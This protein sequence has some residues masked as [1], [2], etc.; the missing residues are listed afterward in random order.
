MGCGE[1]GR[2]RRGVDGGRLPEA[3]SLT[4]GSSGGASE[5]EA[6]E[7]LLRL[8]ILERDR[9]WLLERR[10]LAGIAIWCEDQPVT[11]TKE[12][13]LSVLVRTTPGTGG[14]CKG[15]AGATGKG[16][17]GG[18]MLSDS[19]VACNGRTGLASGGRVNA[20][21]LSVVKQTG[22]SQGWEVAWCA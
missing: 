12:S 18:V 7:A 9:V 15:E 13:S 11:V 14:S 16:L 8:R 4:D 20:E 1:K 22:V 21:K 3:G 10:P 19:I 17:G 2:L 6:L 5:I